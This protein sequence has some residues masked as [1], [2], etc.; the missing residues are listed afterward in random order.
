MNIFY[1]AFYGSLGFM[2]AFVAVTIFSLI[3]IVPGIFIIK[4]FN[5]KDTKPLEK[6]QKEQYLGAV[7]CLIGLLPWFRYLFAGFGFE[8]GEALFNNLFE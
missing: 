3:F 7:L 4:K 1:G 6:L 5:K 2:S 8:A